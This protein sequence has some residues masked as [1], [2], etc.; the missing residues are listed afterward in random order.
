MPE[1]TLQECRDRIGDMARQESKQWFINICKDPYIE[2]YLYYTYS[3]EHEFGNLKLSNTQ[4]TGYLLAD[5]Q[6]FDGWMTQE[7]ARKRIIDI[8]NKLPILPYGEYLPSR[9]K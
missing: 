2:Y 4:D 5:P 9:I 8:A 6:R 3:T 1:I 7:Q